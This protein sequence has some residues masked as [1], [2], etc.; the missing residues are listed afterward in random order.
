M[1]FLG[2][3]NPQWIDLGISVLFSVA[4][5]VLGRRLV[6]FLMGP[7]ASRLAQRTSTTLDDAVLG[8]VRLPLY[9]FLV[10][11]ALKVAIGRLDFVPESW[12]EPLDTF[13]Y[14]LN[15]L[16]G[17]VLLWRLVNDLF[18]WYGREIATHTETKLDEQ[19]LPFFRRVALGIVG[20]IGIIVLLGHFE[21]EVSALV[22]T[23]GVGSLAIALAAQ[24]AL[25]DTISGFIIMIDRPFRIGDRVQI[26]DLDTW[27]DVVDIGLRSTRIRTRDNRMI[28][29]PNSVIGKSLVVNYSYPD[30]QYRIQVHIGIDYRS[31][32]ELARRTMIEAVR[33][34]DG[35]VPERKV[36]ALFLEFGDTALIF[37][38]RWWIDSYVDTRR[39]FDKVNTAV[40][41][42][43]NEAGVEIPMP[44]FEVHH[45]FEDKDAGRAAGMPG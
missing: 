9:W 3:T 10:L 33:G 15:V 31:D 23:L 14:L 7:V 44:Q 42:K 18:V 1:D 19:L 38:V 2:L 25:S 29:V 21:I 6:D 35:V 8:A 5:V 28:I 16:V 30:R 13:F 4:V 41:H 27:G 17:F 32:V 40:L 22:T 45:R 39:M 12:S 36:E 37:R 43:L 24:A 26:Q 34:V 11:L 20:F